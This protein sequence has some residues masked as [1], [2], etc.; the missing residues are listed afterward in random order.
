MR[1]VYNKEDY[2]L[3]GYNIVSL[4]S[5]LLQIF[6]RNEMDMFIQVNREEETLVVS[7]G[8]DGIDIVKYELR[9]MS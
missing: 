8:I 4:Q 5:K 9:N 6:A 3:W 1:F 2:E 7:N